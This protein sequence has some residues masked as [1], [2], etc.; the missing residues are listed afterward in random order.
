MQITYL[1]AFFSFDGN[2][3][4]FSFPYS[5][6]L[7]CHLNLLLFKMN[8]TVFVLPVYQN[9]STTVSRVEFKANNFIS[10]SMFILYFQSVYLGHLPQAMGCRTQSPY[11]YSFVISAGL[12]KLMLHFFKENHHIVMKKKTELVTYHQIYQPF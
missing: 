11:K 8:G 2:G 10:N 6:L 5:F 3:Y 4:I 7:K 9:S 12:G 1:L